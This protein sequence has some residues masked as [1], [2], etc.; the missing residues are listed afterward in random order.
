MVAK[1]RLRPHWLLRLLARR[2]CL[3]H[4]V[5]RLAVSDRR[6]LFGEAFQLPLLAGFGEAKVFAARHALGS[7][8]EY[9]ETVFSRA[10]E[11]QDAHRGRTLFNRPTACFV[12]LNAGEVVSPNLIDKQHAE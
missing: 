9:F 5:E 1:L 4:L 3:Q 10:L 6:M 12:G 7:F 2:H 8:K 11:F